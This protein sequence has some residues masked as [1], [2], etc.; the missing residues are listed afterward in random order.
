MAAIKSM[1]TTLVKSMS[2]SEVADL[3]IADLLSIGE[4]GVE[5]AEQEVTTL[6]SPNGYR[7]FIA[8]LK[9][10]GEVAL[11]GIIKSE[12]AMEAMLALAESQSVEEFTVTFLNGATWVFNAFVKSF[13]E[14]ESTIEGVRNFSASLRISGAPVY[15]SPEVSA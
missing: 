10:A 2:G 6:D 8:G 5:S 9:D 11:S 7:E 13:K 3:T 15:T 14:G 1:G 12:T 4:I